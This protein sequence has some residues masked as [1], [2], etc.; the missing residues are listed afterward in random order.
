M[1]NLKSTGTLHRLALAILF[2]GM[3]VFP[4]NLIAAGPA[5]MRA[6]ET[7]ASQHI[8]E[9]DLK[10]PTSELVTLSGDTLE[11]AWSHHKG[12]TY[13][14][15][16]Y[17]FRLYRG[18]KMVEKNLIFKRKIATNLSSIE[19]GSD[20]FDSGQ[21]YTWSLRQVYSRNR[22]SKRGYQSFRVEKE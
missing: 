6:R 11:F 1:K 5:I 10:R 22:K 8:P 21:M 15:R 2:I 20:M 17:D 12:S 18:I 7:R 16:Y 14:L 19:L 9:P 4:T 3:M 13:D